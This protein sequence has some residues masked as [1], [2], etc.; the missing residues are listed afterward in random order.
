M[1]ELD[2]RWHRNYEAA[3]KRLQLK[4][5]AVA[6]LGG[7]CVICGYDK[8]PTAFDFHHLDSSTK[9]FT[10]SAKATWDDSF[11]AELRKCVLLCANCHREVHA[12]WHPQY[13]VTEDDDNSRDDWEPMIDANIDE[14]L[15][16]GALER[17]AINQ[18]GS[19]LGG[20]TRFR[21]PAAAHAGGPAGRAGGPA[22][23]GV[24]AFAG[25]DAFGKA[26]RGRSG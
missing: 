24:L 3:Q 7:R 26:R 5:R 21:Q 25:P 15:Q 19:R 2:D 4:E 11:E 6:F 9:D 18:S 20:G 10:I 8:C 12:G 22:F 17:D 14:A 1:S 23:A 13:L 16:K